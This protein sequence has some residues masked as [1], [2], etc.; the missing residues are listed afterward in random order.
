M[1]VQPPEGGTELK[2]LEHTFFFISNI[3]F[4]RCSILVSYVEKSPRMLL[5]RPGSPTRRFA[6]IIIRPF[7]YLFII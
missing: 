5:V 2:K 4:I 7:Y 1:N 6:I 3:C